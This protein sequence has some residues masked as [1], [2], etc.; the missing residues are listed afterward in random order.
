MMLFDQDA[1]SSLNPTVANIII[2]A[3]QVRSKK[4]TKS[5]S[6]SSNYGNEKSM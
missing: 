4:T 1:G 2:G 3:V 6:L 5:D